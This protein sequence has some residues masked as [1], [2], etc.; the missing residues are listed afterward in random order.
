MQDW[1]GSRSM[2]SSCLLRAAIF[3]YTEEINDAQYA[4]Q[5]IMTTTFRRN[6]VSCNN[7][8]FPGRML[9]YEFIS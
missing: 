9:V 3:R 2:T 6:N 5:A 7:R 1:R 8:N 4:N